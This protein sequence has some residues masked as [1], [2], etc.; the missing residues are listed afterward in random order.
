MDGYG[1]TGRLFR[2]AEV[3]AVETKFTVT[4]P[5]AVP[6]STQSI[7]GVRKSVRVALMP[8]LQWPTPGIM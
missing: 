7:I 5:G 3:C 8:P 1:N 4:L 2:M 6:F